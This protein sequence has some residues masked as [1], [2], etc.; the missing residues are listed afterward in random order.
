MCWSI[1]TPS[2]RRSKP[3]RRRKSY[4]EGVGQAKDY[5]AA[6]RRRFAYASNGKRYLPHRHATGAEGLVDAYP[7]AAGTVGRTFAEPNRWR[8]RF[9][10]V[11]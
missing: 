2:W 7:D 3:R 5:A 6:C 4:T 10:A 9:A 8:D 11:P 1:A